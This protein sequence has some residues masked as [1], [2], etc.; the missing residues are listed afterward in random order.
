[1]VAAHG[2]RQGAAQRGWSC[3]A[4]QKGVEAGQGGENHGRGAR[5]R[6]PTWF[7]ALLQDTRL[8][9]IVPSETHGNQR[10]EF[11]FAS[12]VMGKPE[13]ID[14][15]AAGLLARQGSRQRGPCLGILGSGEEAV[16]V[17][18]A[19]GGLRL[20]AQR[21][22]DMAVVDAMDAGAVAAG[23]VPGMGDDM[24]DPRKASIRSS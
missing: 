7:E 8:W 9:Q 22:D 20:A 21:V 16:A 14:H 15:L 2:H 12:F 5:Q 3:A 11:R 24:G 1:M 13:Q 6:A 23:A 10:G 4:L 18:Q 17:G 19:G